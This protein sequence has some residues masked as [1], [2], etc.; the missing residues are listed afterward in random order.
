[1]L[2]TITFIDTARARR[3]DPTTSHEAADSNDLAESSAYVLLLLFAHGPLADH[4]LTM[5]AAGDMSRYL[6]GVIAYTPQRLRTARH[7]LVESGHVVD[8]GIYRLTASR[9]R[10]KVWEL[11]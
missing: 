8:T 9:R 7:E 4:E 3:S 2:P 10:A 6:P 11:A 5:K 1:M